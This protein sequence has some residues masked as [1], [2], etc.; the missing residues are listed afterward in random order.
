[1]KIAYLSGPKRGLQVDVENSVGRA[2][3]DAGIASAIVE[4][5]SGRAKLTP[6]WSVEVITGV[7]RRMLCIR[8]T[9]GAQTTIYTGL[10]K[11]IRTIGGWPCP[12]PTKSEYERQ[13]EA[14]P[15]LRDIYVPPDAGGAA[16]NRRAAEDLKS[17]ENS[18][19]ENNCVPYTPR[20]EV[21]LSF[22]NDVD[23]I[24]TPG[25]PK[26]PEDGGNHIVDRPWYLK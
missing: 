20:P 19:K 11:S 10:P 4:P 14:N 17:F 15:K 5:G 24:Y 16:Q 2:L 25:D 23:V 22:D 26:N 6:K 18:M 21:K 9:I 13:W 3:V 1:M 7:D 12:L 8:M